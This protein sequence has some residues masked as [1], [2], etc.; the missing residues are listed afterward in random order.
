MIQRNRIQV[1]TA[2]SFKNRSALLHALLA[3][4]AVATLVAVVGIAQA[5]AQETPANAPTTTERY[6]KVREAEK[7]QKNAKGQYEDRYGI[8]YDRNPLRN[9][10]TD[11]DDG[12]DRNDKKHQ[13]KKGGHDSNKNKHDKATGIENANQHRP[14]HARE[15]YEAAKEGK[16]SKGQQAEEDDR[17]WFSRI[18]GWGKDRD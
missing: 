7:A 2:P 16:D 6:E 4:I 14:E 12:K 17:G 1:L 5:Q 10:D 9:Q 13:G 15:N 11:W 3:G 8:E 18:F